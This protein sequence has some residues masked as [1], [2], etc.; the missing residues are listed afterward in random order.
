[1]QAYAAS[2]LRVNKGQSDR[3]DRWQQTSS[4]ILPPQRCATLCTMFTVSAAR[5]LDDADTACATAHEWRTTLLIARPHATKLLLLRP[6]PT[7]ATSA[8]A[9]P[10][11]P[12]L[13][14]AR[15]IL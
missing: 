9:G 11:A 7:S 8:S 6:K 12:G 15:S 14:R 4:T 2:G 13:D 10:I 1:M 5:R 3:A